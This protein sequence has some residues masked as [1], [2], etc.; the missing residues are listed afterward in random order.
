[1][2]YYEHVQVTKCEI[3]QRLAEWFREQGNLII[4]L[5][6]KI[7]LTLLNYHNDFH[8]RSLCKWKQN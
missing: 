1:M 8:S 4:S 5:T 2:L 6:G 7:N 3:R